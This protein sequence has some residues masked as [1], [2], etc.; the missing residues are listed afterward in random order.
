M[1]LRGPVRESSV[2][3]EIILNPVARGTQEKRW[4]RR[5]PDQQFPLNRIFNIAGSPKDKNTSPEMQNGWQP[6]LPAVRFDSN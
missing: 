4:Q 6:V 2:L 1:A 5:D 3:L